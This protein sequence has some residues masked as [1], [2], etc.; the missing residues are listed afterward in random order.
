M[1]QLS[2]MLQCRNQSMCLCIFPGQISG[3]SMDFHWKLAT[4]QSTLLR[5]LPSFKTFEPCRRLWRSATQ[6]S[7]AMAPL[8]TLGSRLAQL[9]STQLHATKCKTK[10]HEKSRSM[11]EPRYS[12]F[13]NVFRI[14]LHY[15][16]MNLSFADLSDDLFWH[17]WSFSV[18]VLLS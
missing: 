15:F 11:K 8:K 3:I 1:S 16:A 10:K 14:F 13:W 7:R 5:P 9:K 6:Q 4:A 17:I 18:G 2:L 12:Q